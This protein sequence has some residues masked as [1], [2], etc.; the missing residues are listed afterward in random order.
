MCRR[1]RLR[2]CRR[3]VRQGPSLCPSNPRLPRTRNPPTTLPNLL[4]AP[5]P[6]LP[7]PK[8][9]YH[10]PEPP[11]TPPN[12]YEQEY[13]DVTPKY[14]YN[15]GVADGYSGANFAASESRDGYKIEGQAYTVD[16]PDGR[17]QI[18]NY[19]DTADVYG[20]LRS[21]TGE[22]SVCRVQCAHLQASSPRP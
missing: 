12:E 14:N 19:V 9:S 11:T 10:D 20:K 4:P 5:K 22:A 15:Y 13:A 18:V 6:S 3:S 1:P 8:P 21:P 2:G 7:A 16:L 17:K